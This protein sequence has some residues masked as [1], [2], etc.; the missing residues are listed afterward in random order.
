VEDVLDVVVTAPVA[1]EEDEVTEAAVEEAVEVQDTAYESLVSIW[2]NSK[3]E[4]DPAI[5]DE[6]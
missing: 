5:F 3:D 6:S 2:S 1:E 4:R